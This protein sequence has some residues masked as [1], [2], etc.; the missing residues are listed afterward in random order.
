MSALR[1]KNVLYIIMFV[2]N[3]YI[4][5]LKLDALVNECSKQLQERFVAGQEVEV[6]IDGKL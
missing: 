5:V 3:L 1:L 2:V 4:G 6:T